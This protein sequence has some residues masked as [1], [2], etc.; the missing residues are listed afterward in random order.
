[1]RFRIEQHFD[2][3]LL[4][5]EEELLAPD[6]LQRLAGL[7]KLGSPE[8]LD[9]RTEPG[10]VHR[11][12]RYR[13]TGDVNA[14]VRRVVDPARLTWVEVSANDRRTHCTTWHIVP[15]HY[16]SM[17]RGSGT[18]QLEADGATGTRRVTD[19]EIRVSVPFVAGKVERAIV[20]GLT[21]HAAGEETVLNTWLA[22]RQGTTDS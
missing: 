12:V 22:A 9:E 14:A 18:F 7:P 16:R 1:V 4:T 2:G 17:I 13:F 19:A 21:D 20:S 6:H 8:L 11:R 3:P 10:V 5:V 15:D